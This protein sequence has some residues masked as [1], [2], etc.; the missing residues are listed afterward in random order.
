[1]DLKQRL[2]ENPFI[3]APM[4]GITDN[5]FRNFAMEMSSSVVVSELVSAS[6]IKYGSQQTFKLMKFDEMQRPVGIQLFGETPEVIAEGAKL[7]EEKGAD[8]VDMNFGCPVNKVVKKGAGSAVL[9]D[10]KQLRD[11]L[12]TVKSAIN[13]PLTIKIR[14]GWTF[15]TRN[16]VEVCQ[17]AYDEGVEW[18][19][20]HGRDRKQAYTGKADWDYIAEVKAKSKL[21]IIGNGDIL[22]AQQA[23]EAL[24]KAG[25][26]GVMIGRGALKNP[27]IF[28]ESLALYRG[29]TFD[30]Q[31][32]DYMKAFGRLKYYLEKECD[33]RILKIQ[34]RKFAS[35]FSAGYP[36][37]ASFRK[38]L[39]QTETVDEAMDLVNDFYESIKGILQEDTS[40]DGF[41]MGGHG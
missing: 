30:P 18:V 15:E 40:G 13:I 9:K 7:V 36:G 35:W 26:D 22:S 38:S 1:M 31:D 23:N 19:A 39:F 14:T 29:L 41:L 10:T 28:E 17:V 8:F 27:Y 4:A 11:I 20:I 12:R 34:I 24:Q 33:E 21:P 25:V 5:A 2:K 37:S 3:L 32:R 6:G 16:A